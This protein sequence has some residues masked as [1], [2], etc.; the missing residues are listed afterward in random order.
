MDRVIVHPSQLPAA[1]DILELQV[2]ALRESGRLIAAITGS[3]PVVD[4]VNCAPTLPASMAVSMS[5]GTA[6]W[7][8][9]V[10]G[11]SYGVLAPDL[12]ATMKSGSYEGQTIPVSAPVAPGT[13]VVF[14][15]QATFAESDTD[16]LV[17]DYYNAANPSQPYSGPS[18]SG[19]AEYTRRADRC[20]VSLKAGSPAATG[21]AVAPGADPGW[22]PLW[23]ILVHAGATAIT[24]GDITPAPGAPRFTSRLTSSPTDLSGYATNSG[25]ASEARDRIAADAVLQVE[26][27]TKH[28]GYR[29]FVA[30][31]TATTWVVPANIDRARVTAVGGGAGAGSSGTSL[32]GGGGGSGGTGISVIGGLT[33]GEGISLSV[34]AAGVGGTSGGNGAPGGSSSFGVYLTASGGQPGQGGATGQSGGSGGSAFGASLNVGGGAGGDGSSGLSRGGDGAASSMGGGGRAASAPGAAQNGV[35]FGSGGGAGYFSAGVPGGNGQQGI[36]IVEW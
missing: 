27:D 22:V 29:N 35:A 6:F 15:V 33:P 23:L 2:N 34:G 26:L 5:A 1:E 12:R 11:G 30:F 25:L 10:D 28:V 13:D 32:A 14:L 19:A 36:V 31:G 16:P 17:L 9:V 18:N 20:V 3:S 21:Q 4:G 7:P 8:T 24:A